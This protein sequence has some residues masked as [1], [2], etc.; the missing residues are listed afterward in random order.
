MPRVPLEC[1]AL[2]SSRENMAQMVAEGYDTAGA[3][4]D[5][6]FGIA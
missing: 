3:L 1:N 5:Q 4:S 2:E 6:F